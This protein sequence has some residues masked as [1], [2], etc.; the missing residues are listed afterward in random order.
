MG[1]IGP[2][3]WSM[4]EKTGQKTFLNMQADVLESMSKAVPKEKWWV[5]DHPVLG[6]I[7]V[8]RETSYGEKRSDVTEVLKISFSEE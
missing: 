7:C 6:T 4:V 2:P 1:R 8:K 3:F 5:A